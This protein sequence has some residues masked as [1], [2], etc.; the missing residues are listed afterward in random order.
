[1]RTCFYIPQSC[2]RYVL[3]SGPDERVVLAYTQPMFQKLLVVPQIATTN[4]RT[5]ATLNVYSSRRTV[6]NSDLRWGSLGY[7]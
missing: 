4:K 2:Y 6:S 3:Q 1:M 7:A 5:G